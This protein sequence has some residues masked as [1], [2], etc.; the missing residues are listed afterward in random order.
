M[1]NIIFRVD[2][3][4][5]HGQVIEGWI[6]NFNI[7][8][9]Y[10]ANNYVREDILQQTIFQSAIPPK[11]DLFFFSLNE[12]ISR[13]RNEVRGKM[14]LVLFESVDDLMMCESLIDSDTYVNIGC[15]AS[16][17][18][19]ISLSDTVFLEPSEVEYLALL[20]AKWDIH[21]KKLPWEN[22]AGILGRF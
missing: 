13:W 6:K 12:F 4:L 15:V 21:I 11:T 7:P 8:K 2:D 19:S 20:A 1:K 5:I 3:R 14:S 17:A 10:I 22:E 18:H 9:V 16:R